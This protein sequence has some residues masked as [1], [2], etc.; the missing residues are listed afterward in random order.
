MAR[1]ELA[2]GLD[3]IAL[4][5]VHPRAQHSRHLPWVGRETA[6]GRRIA[7]YVEVAGQRAQAVGVDHHGLAEL[8]HQAAD[9]L[10]RLAIEADARPDRQGVARA[11]EL[12][13]R[14]A[15]LQGEHA[16]GGLRQ[17]LGH[18]FE[19]EARDNRLLAHRCRHR[20]EPDAA[21]HR[22]HRSER[23]RAGLAE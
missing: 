15:R 5:L 6:R 4:D 18:R 2:G 10:H 3:P 20:D 12:D 14:L 9:D 8:A 22:R 13:D 21:A 11:G 17:R 23:R 19:H 16:R 7:Q 1:C